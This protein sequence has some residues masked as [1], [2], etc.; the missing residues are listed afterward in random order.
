[1]S[2]GLEAGSPAAVV[3]AVEVADKRGHMCVPESLSLASPKAP[4]ASGAKIRCS[5]VESVWAGCQAYAH[6]WMCIGITG[7]SCK[8][9][10]LWSAIDEAKEASV[11]FVDSERGPLITYLSAT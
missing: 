3:D 7:V 8:L 1:M 10:D 5:P 2:L 9:E 6:P 4:L 11:V